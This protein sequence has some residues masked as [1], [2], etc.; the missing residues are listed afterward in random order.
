[1]VSLRVDDGSQAQRKAR[2]AGTRPV[3]DRRAIPGIFPPGG[4]GRPGL[5][6][7]RPRGA[8]LANSPFRS[9]YDGVFHTTIEMSLAE[10]GLHMTVLHFT[11]D[12]LMTLFFVVAGLEIKRELSTGELRTWGRATL[13]LIAAGGGMIVPALIYLGFNPSGP[14]H[15]GW[16]IPMATDI[17]FSLG[18]L[19]LVRRRVPASLFVF[20]MALAIFD[21]L[22]AILVIAF[23]Y[24]GQIHVSSLAVSALLAAGLFLLGRARVQRTWP[25]ALLGLALWA[26]VLDS[27]IHATVAGVIIGLALPTSPRR[28]A[29]DVLDELDVAITSLRRQCERRGVA[30]D[31]SIAAIER[32]LESVQSPLD[33]MM[34]RLHGVVAF[35]IVPLFALANAGVTF[36]LGPALGS[37]VTLGVLLGLCVGKPVGILGATWVATRIGLA[38]RPTNAT[39][40]QILGISVVAGIGF[41]MS[42]FIG[43]LGLGGLR[44]LED[45]AKVGVLAGSAISAAIGLALLRFSSKSVSTSR[46]H[47]DVPVVLD[48]PRFARGYGV[49]PCNVAGPLLGRTLTELNVRRRFGVTAIGIWRGG[50]DAAARNLEPIGADDPLESGDV[51]LVAGS[52][53]ALD[54]FQSFAHEG[55]DQ[56]SSLPS[57][58]T[59]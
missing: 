38:P 10:R 2:P 35:A 28:Q 57:M 30:P 43:N 49:Q 18:C 17:A 40:V 9:L 11:N 42:L 27:G 48:V 54:D 6:G 36:R 31:G 22:G 15:A 4:R 29:L 5:D 12:A 37:T 47:E 8:R 46:E 33:R 19:S 56:R 41:T 26:F 51:L 16:G 21:D 34:H 53:R 25:Y 24:G 7:Q 23:F 50:P 1:M 44:E 52:D 58:S 45:Q 32:H 59:A 14:A 55:S 20:L 13:P 3:R 39:W